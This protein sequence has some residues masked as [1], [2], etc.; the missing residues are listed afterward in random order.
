MASEAAI[1]EPN[2]AGHARIL[3]VYLLAS[4]NYFLFL[5]SPP[6]FGHAWRS[7]STRSAR[8]TSLKPA[9]LSL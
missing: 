5:G 3:Q 1:I 7:T 4:C 6:I 9:L 2:V 8:K